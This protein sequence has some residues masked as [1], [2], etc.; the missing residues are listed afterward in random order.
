MWTIRQEQTEAFRQH[1]LKKFEDEMVVHLRKFA[2]QPS[3]VAGEAAVRAA[4]RVGIDNAGKYGFTNRGPL[5][6]YI[7]LM[8][9]FG[10]YFDSDPQHPWAASVLS[11][12]ETMGQTA[13][14]ERLFKGMTS[15][16]GEVPGT[17]NQH[18]LRALQH[19]SA[20]RVEEFASSNLSLEEFAFHG[21]QAIYPQACSFMG[22]QR[23]RAVVHQ[24][25]EKARHF[26]LDDSKGMLLMIAL[27][28]FMGHAFPMDP[29]CGWIARRLNQERFP[30]SAKRTD[31]LYKKAALYLRHALG[32]TQN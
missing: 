18:Y 26:G 5:R 17:D 31:E 10:S 7:E 30:D 13:R 9:M 23:T 25:V 6:F 15:Y 14:A 28:L 20:T 29:L 24:G 22:D 4:I 21:L 27:G 3:K 1:H 16:L 12:T 2:P 32:E 11:D 19:L 8:F